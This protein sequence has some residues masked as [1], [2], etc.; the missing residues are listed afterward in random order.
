M[1]D[2]LQRLLKLVSEFLFNVQVH[3]NVPKPPKPPKPPDTEAQILHVLILILEA[4]GRQNK[5]LR[6]TEANNERRHK[7]LLE[8]IGSKG[9]A[10]RVVFTKVR[11]EPIP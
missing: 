9:D 3:F 10:T 1:K 7:E 4:T 11:R 2:L 6:T 8:A 5:I